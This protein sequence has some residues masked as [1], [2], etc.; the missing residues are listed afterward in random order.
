MINWFM[1]MVVCLGSQRLWSMVVKFVYFMT[2]DFII[3]I[4]IAKLNPAESQL[5]HIRSDKIICW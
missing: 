1:V 4:V 5:S 2:R 3:V